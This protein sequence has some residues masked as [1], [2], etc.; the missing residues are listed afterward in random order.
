MEIV[1]SLSIGKYIYK[2]K[3]VFIICEFKMCTSNVLV[4]A[5]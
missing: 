2:M 3:K 1:F 4:D 5:K